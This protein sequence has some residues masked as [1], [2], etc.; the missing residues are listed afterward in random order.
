AG[1]TKYGTPRNKRDGK[2]SRTN[3]DRRRRKPSAAIAASVPVPNQ[4]C[5]STWEWA[6]S[7]HVPV[8]QIYEWHVRDLIPPKGIE[9]QPDAVFGFER[10]ISPPPFVAEISNGRVWGAFGAV[11]TYDN[12][13]LWDVS[14]IPPMIPGE[15]PIFR[16][17]ALPPLQRTDETIA[18]LTFCESGMYYHWMFDVISRLD[19]L[20]RSG[21]RIDRYIVNGVRHAF[22]TETLTLLGIPHEKQI[23]CYDGFHLQA[24]NLIVPVAYTKKWGPHYW[25]LRYLRNELLLKRGLEPVAEFERIY[26]SRSMAASRRVRNEDQVFEVLRP[27]GFKR[28]QLESYSV[29][30]QALIFC[31]AKI[32]VSPHGSGLTNLAF[33]QKG[34][35][36]VELFAPGFPVYVFWLICNQLDLDYYHLFGEGER[37]TDTVN[38]YRGYEDI[39]IDIE[40]FISVLELAGINT[41]M[42]VE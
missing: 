41:S 7:Q 8:W 15:H 2:R 40:K 6:A 9:K 10:F 20:N 31:S 36:V 14:V 5:L 29:L 32:V 12:R 22:Q 39:D 25:Q 11:I 21:I 42:E 33:C 17:P 28:I 19:L 1:G 18:V 27:L 34:T 30:Q 13:L 26:I 24:K 16:Q 38:P 23:H 4:F 3:K 35:K 37:V